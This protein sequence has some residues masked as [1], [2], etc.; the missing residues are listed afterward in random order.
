MTIRRLPPADK[1]LDVTITVNK[2]LLPYFTQWYQRKKL[3]GEKPKAFALR[4]LKSSAISDYLSDMGKA[5]INQIEEKK[6]IAI[7]ALHTDASTL[8]SEVD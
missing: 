2:N 3:D 6:A 5:E 7:E 1:S 4:I 8:Q